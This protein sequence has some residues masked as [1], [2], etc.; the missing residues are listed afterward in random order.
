MLELWQ[1]FL[2]WLWRNGAWLGRGDNLAIVIGV[3]GLGLLYIV[4][5]RRG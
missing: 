3:L 5:K 4:F 1:G 2:D